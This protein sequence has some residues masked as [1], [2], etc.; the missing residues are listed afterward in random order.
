[1]AQDPLQN[2]LLMR[3]LENMGISLDNLHRRQRPNAQKPAPRPAGPSKPAKAGNIM[4]RLHS[5]TRMPKWDTA[6]VAPKLNPV[7][8]PSES[9]AMGS[10]PKLPPS[11]VTTPMVATQKDFRLESPAA[12]PQSSSKRELP[13]ETF[14]RLTG[15]DWG[16]GKKSGE[17]ERMMELLGIVGKPGSAEANLALQ[18]ALMENSQNMQER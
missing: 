2:E 5:S 15:M 12:S 7:K 14:Q 10:M 13:F 1:M 8:S 11:P 4:D 3:E 17:I 6:S 9:A 18:K 16:V